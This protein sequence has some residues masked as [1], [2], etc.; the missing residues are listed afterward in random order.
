MHVYRV[1]HYMTHKGPFCKAE[2]VPNKYGLNLTYHG[3][4]YRGMPSPFTDGMNDIFDRFDHPKFAFPTLSVFMDFWRIETLKDLQEL[5]HV[6]VCLDIPLPELVVGLSGLQVAFDGWMEY[7][8][9]SIK[10]LVDTYMV[11]NFLLM[12]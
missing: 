6:L 3:H 9:I 1:E 11:H 8:I 12:G 2:T 7:P 4:E 10:E 5:G